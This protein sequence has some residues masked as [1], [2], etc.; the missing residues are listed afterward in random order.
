MALYFPR[1]TILLIGIK[2]I[3]K[4]VKLIDMKKLARKILG[5]MI[6]GMSAVFGCAEV[7]ADASTP[8]INWIRLDF[9]PNYILRGEN[10]GNG[11]VEKVIRY[12]STQLSQYEMHNVD[13]SRKRFWHE[14][15]R[16]QNYCEAGAQRTTERQQYAYFSIPMT[17]IPPAKIVLNQTSWEALG[18]P[19]SMSL[20]ALLQV[21]SLSGSIIS[22]RSYGYVLDTLLKNNELKADA[23]FLRHVIDLDSLYSMIS[24]NR[25]D[26]TI[27]YEI[28]LN[29]FLQKRS[30]DNLKLVAIEEE[31]K[32]HS[33]HVVC[34]KN[35]WGKKI[36]EDI[37][38]VLKKHRVLESFRQSFSVYGEALNGAFYQ[39]YKSDLD[40]SQ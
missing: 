31:A 16:R 27:D 37:N 4:Q 30:L 36:I 22:T 5:L 34:T 10:A 25:L 12:L 19:D 40:A 24:M 23:N 14:I 18:K 1:Y 11:A 29:R 15:E 7:F 35:A 20:S 21:D 9:P 26:F 17:L 2:K 38:V 28:V 32:Y 3:A 39:R 13:M 6:V 33:L 8:S